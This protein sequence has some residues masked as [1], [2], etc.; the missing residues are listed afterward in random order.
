M[1]SASERRI[2][3]HLEQL[4]QFT[5]TPGQGTT[6]MSYSVQDKQARDYLKAEMQ[7]VGLQV[8]ED[9]IGNIYGRLDG[10]QSDLPP[11]MIGSHFDSVPNGGAFDGPAGVVMG[12]EIAT[13]FHQLGLK[14]YYPLEIVALVEEEGASFGGGLLASRAIAGLVTPEDLKTMRDSQGISAAE[15]MQAA[16]F[17]ADKVGEVVRRPGQI[18]AFI[19]LHIEQGPVLEQ[20]GEDVGL[21]DVIVGISQLVITVK[22]KAGHAGT[23]PMNH[24]ADALLAACQIIQQVPQLAIEAGDATVATVGKLQVYPNGANVIPDKVVFTVDVRSKNEDKLRWV[25]EQI[26]SV[27]AASVGQGIETQ[28]ERML[29][30]K[31]TQLNKDIFGLLRSNSEELGLASRTMVS[32]AGHDAMIFAGITDVGLVFVPSKNGLSH[33]PDEWTDYDQI[34]KGI[35]VIFATVKQLTKA[36]QHG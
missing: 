17:N 6:R 11:V 26:D 29:F 1:I 31:P 34:E 23:T 27:A 7:A 25:L 33:H 4:A 28:V 10:E 14:P 2:Q 13:R 3:R 5:A 18:K 9:A 21:V 19:E 36:T 24:R 8:R 30:V 35:D 15:R 12:L 22:G 16:G 32:G 20:A